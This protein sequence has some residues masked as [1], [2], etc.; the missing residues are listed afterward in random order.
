[1]SLLYYGFDLLAMTIFAVDTQKMSLSF[2]SDGSGV[3]F[4]TRN[5]VACHFGISSGC[6]QENPE[7]G[8]EYFNLKI[9]AL[10]ATKSVLIG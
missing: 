6:D 2:P 8:T 4:S 1:M 3:S 7:A 10:H 9:I 5:D